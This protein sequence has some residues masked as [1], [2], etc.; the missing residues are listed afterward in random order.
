M[1][2]E[3]K[4]AKLTSHIYEEFLIRIREENGMVSVILSTGVRIQGHVMEF[5]SECLQLSCGRDGIVTIIPTAYITSIAE[6]TN[7]PNINTYDRNKN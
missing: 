7:N 4:N 5:D 1:F 6:R 2:E 3:I